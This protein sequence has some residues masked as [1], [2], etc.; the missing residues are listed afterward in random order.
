MT[1][2]VSVKRVDESDLNELLPLVRAYCDFY[3]VAP[4]DESL[5]AISRALI[6]D[7]VGEGVQII[8]RTSDDNPVGFATL[9]W[10][11]DTTIG[12]RLAIM[13]DLYVTDEARGTGAAQALMAGLVTEARLRGVVQLGWQTA[14]DNK[15]AQ[16]L[17]DKTGAE[18][19]TWYDYRLTV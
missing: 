19:S 15:R 4:T 6:A 13:H 5:L 18:K 17:Y 2:Q 14:L 9:Y 8:A 11:W 1:E 16:A 10:S 3:Q 7:P 12:G